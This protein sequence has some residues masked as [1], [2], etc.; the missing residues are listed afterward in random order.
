MHV[1]GWPLP[2]S[3]VDRSESR[4]SRCASARRVASSFMAITLYFAPMRNK[5]ALLALAACGAS[6]APTAATLQIGTDEGSGYVALVDGGTIKAYMGPQGGFH[7]YLSVRATGIDPGAASEP[8]TTC[9]L[10]GSFRNPCVDFTVTDVASGRVLDIFSP[11]RLPLVAEG[12][13]FD[14]VPGRLVQLDIRSLDEV[15]G[16]RLRLAAALTDSTRPPNSTAPPVPAATEPP[17]VAQRP[18]AGL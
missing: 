11:L 15:D 6:A 3:E 16:K 1:V 4:R 2:A 7:V 17:A 9:T 12:G 13:S 8:P 5:L 10:A 18:D 14:I